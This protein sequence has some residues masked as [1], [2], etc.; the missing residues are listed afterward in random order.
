MKKYDDQI[1]RVALNPLSFSPVSII[2]NVGSGKT[3][4]LEKYRA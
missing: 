2:G 4:F 3:Y 1:E